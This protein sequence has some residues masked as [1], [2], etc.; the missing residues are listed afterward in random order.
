MLKV[1]EIEQK[2]GFLFPWIL[3]SR[4]KFEHRDV[5]CIDVLDFVF[6]F[7]WIWPRG[8]SS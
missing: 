1:P 5:A 4:L 3:R 8:F 2:V 7:V 6:R